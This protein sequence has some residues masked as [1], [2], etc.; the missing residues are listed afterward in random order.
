MT[1]SML[2]ICLQCLMIKH[3]APLN[4]QHITYAN[5]QKTLETKFLRTKIWYN[6]QSIKAALLMTEV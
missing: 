4:A 3:D 1:I 6:S 2:V 5:K